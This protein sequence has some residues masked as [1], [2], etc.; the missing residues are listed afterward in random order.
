MNTQYADLVDRIQAGEDISGLAG[1]GSYVPAIRSGQLDNWIADAMTAFAID[2][3]T[4]KT[5]GVEAI[6][7]VYYHRLDYA[8]AGFT[9]AVNFFNV[10]TADFV[11]NFEGSSGL[12]PNYGFMLQSIGIDLERGLTVGG[13]YAATPTNAT[14]II[15]DVDNSII[16]LEATR[17]VFDAGRAIFRIQQKTY[18]D[19]YGLKHFSIGAGASIEGFASDTTTA[20]AAQRRAVASVNNGAPFSANRGYTFQRPIPILPGDRPA[21]SVSFQTAIPIPI[22]STLRA[23]MF[24]YLFRFA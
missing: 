1:L 21:L 22:A 12:A 20:G 2:G 4:P 15:A 9:A 23:Q 17:R 13:T 7:T 11:T 3:R 10:A 5:F 24:G 6:P 19:V 16:S 14:S 18:C 8:V